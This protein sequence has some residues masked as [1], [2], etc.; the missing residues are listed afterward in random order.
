MLLVNIIV[1]REE[2]SWESGPQSSGFSARCGSSGNDMSPMYYEGN[3]F[4]LYRDWKR[5]DMTAPAHIRHQ[6]SIF[7]LIYLL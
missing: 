1:I 6:Y 7:V 4:R 5:V 2:S 3:V